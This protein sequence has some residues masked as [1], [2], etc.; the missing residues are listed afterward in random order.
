MAIGPIH[1]FVIGFDRPKLEGAVIDELIK[2]REKGIIRVVDLL[3][4]Y[5]DADGNLA[6][7]DLS[8]FSLADK[9]ELGA[10]IGGLIGL[11]AA[12][13][14]GAEV[15]AEAGA[16]AVAENDYGITAEELDEIAANIPLDS[17]VLI[18]LF[19]HTW[20]IN[21]RD[22]I[23]DAGGVPIAQGMLDPV[24]LVELGA[25]LADAVEA[26]L[27]SVQ[28]VVQKQLKKRIK[29]RV[30]AKAQLEADP[31]NLLPLSL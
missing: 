7:I 9:M 22:A 6:A 11:G 23:L 25:V 24:T 31:L 18:M 29:G 27:A 28:A 17:A 21:L 20:A 19:E 5:K 12:G 1:L 8:D 13:E 14:E 30:V 4:V 15:G 2:V 26:A 16:L 10:V 3:G